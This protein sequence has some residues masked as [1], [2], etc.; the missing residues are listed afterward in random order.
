MRTLG[1]GSVVLGFALVLLSWDASRRFMSARLHS[2]APTV[3]IGHTRA[4][5]SVAPAPANAGREADLPKPGAGGPEPAPVEATRSAVRLNAD[6]RRS[7]PETARGSRDLPALP[8]RQFT[9]GSKAHAEAIAS[10]IAS[11]E[12]RDT[13]EPL[14]RLYFAFFDRVADYEGLNYYIDE[15]DGAVSL[16]SIADEFAGSTEFRLR[17]GTLDNAAFIERLYRNVF[18]A[19]PDSAQ[20]AYWIGQLDAG[21]SRGSVM[22]AFSES[23]A[24][25]TLTANEVFVTLAYA[26]TLRR[27]PDAAGFAHW[28][29]FL[30]AGN[31]CEAVIAGLLGGPRKTR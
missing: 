14:A 23:G 20:R 26:E 13:V 12:Y 21:M 24:F 1:L 17:Y 11:N 4:G 10:T 28:V 6:A 3:E 22:L 5:V 27:A 8:V 19:V 29:R 15:R 7:V 2:E 30:E 18:D 31:S 9:P 16:A 25:R